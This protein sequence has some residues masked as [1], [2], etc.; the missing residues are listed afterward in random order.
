[1]MIDPKSIKKI[2]QKY[3][4]S[5]IY[6]FGSKAIKK[7]SKL[8]DTDIAVLPKD[9]VKKD[10]KDLVLDLIFE[11]SQLFHSDKIDLLVLEGSSLSI[12]YNVISE[13]K[14]LYANNPDVRS[15]YETRIIKLYLDFKKFEEEY[16]ENMRKS[17]RER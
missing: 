14:L 17:I 9:G 13:G 1:M 11:F 4:L 15:D 5:L 2:A 16:Y 12:Q 8:S 6:L 10:R 3:N 7:D